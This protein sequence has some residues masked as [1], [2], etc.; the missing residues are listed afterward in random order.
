MHGQGRAHRADEPRHLRLD[1][2]RA[3]AEGRIDYHAIRRFLGWRGRADDL[4]RR[5]R[6]LNAIFAATGQRIRSFPLK[7]HSISLA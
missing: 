6:V 7:N 1:A 3:D 2:H 4:R 5:A